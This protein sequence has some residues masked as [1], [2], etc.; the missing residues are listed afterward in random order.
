MCAS[1]FRILRTRVRCI[2]SPACGEDSRSSRRLALIVLVALGAL[3]VADGAHA[4]FY[5]GKTLTMIINY[6]AGGPSG[7]LHPRRRRAASWQS[8]AA[9]Q[10]RGFR[11]ARRSGG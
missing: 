1:D 6:P 4:Q 5:K 10:L 7:L 2:P 9:R 11:D 8:G 3:A